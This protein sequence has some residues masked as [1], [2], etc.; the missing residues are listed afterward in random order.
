M[1]DF[2][3]KKYWEEDNVMFYMH[4]RN[5]EAIRQVE[6]TSGGIVFLVPEIITMRLM[7]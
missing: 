1:R 2:F 3:I 4:F 7:G 5:G 6:K